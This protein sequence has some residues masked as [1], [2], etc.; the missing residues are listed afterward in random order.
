VRERERRERERER[1]RD[2]FVDFDIKEEKGDL[3]GKLPLEP[4]FMKAVMIHFLEPTFLS[5]ISKDGP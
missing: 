1:E 2:Q 3:A 5:E 4:G